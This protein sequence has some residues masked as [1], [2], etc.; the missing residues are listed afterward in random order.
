MPPAPDLTPD[1]DYTGPL[2]RDVRESQG[3][4]LKDVSA[5]TKVGLAYLEA[6]EA[7]DFAALPAPVYVRGFVGEIAKSLKLDAAQVARTYVRRYRRYLEER[8]RDA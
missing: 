6:I 5:R 2:L 7:D 8:G 1:T 4:S 3:V